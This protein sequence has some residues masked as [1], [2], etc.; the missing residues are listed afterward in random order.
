MAKAQMSPW[1]G[2]QWE[3]AVLC[4]QPGGRCPRGRRAQH[5]YADSSLLG[6]LLSEGPVG[7][8]SMQP[9]QADAF[10]VNCHLTGIR[11]APPRSFPHQKVFKGHKKE[12]KLGTAFFFSA[13]L[14]TLPEAN[15]YR[16]ELFVPEPGGDKCSIYREQSRVR[17]F[18][19]DEIQRNPSHCP[20]GKLSRVWLASKILFFQ[21][22]ANKL[23]LLS[24]APKSNIPRRS[25]H[26]QGF[27]PLGRNRNRLGLKQNS[28]KTN[29]DKA[30]KY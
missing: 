7:L 5:L 10:R 9:F 28:L 27:V 22:R 4:P 16:V 20:Q 14:H 29:L 21:S 15:S 30:E 12:G 23:I 18:R 24:E 11:L 26:L 19:E 6:T 17:R 13:G 3:R 2:R 25:Y 1:S 8:Q